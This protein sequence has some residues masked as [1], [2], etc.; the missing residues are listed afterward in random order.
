M[1]IRLFNYI[2]EFKHNYNEQT[3]KNEVHFGCITFGVVYQQAVLSV[4]KL[5]YNAWAIQ[6]NDGSL[7]IGIINNYINFVKLA[8]VPLSR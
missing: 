1:I 3:C 6:H 7:C 8:E 4:C 5:K 2:Y